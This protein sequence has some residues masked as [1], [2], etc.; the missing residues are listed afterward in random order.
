MPAMSKEVAGPV[1]Q[2]VDAIAKVAED[3]ARNAERAGDEAKKETRH[4]TRD[5]GDA[6]SDAFDAVASAAGDAAAKAGGAAR[7]LHLDDRVED[8]VKRIRSEFP[9]ERITTLVSN[10][11]REL[12][13]TDKDRYDRAYLRGWTRARTSFVGVGLLAGIAAG[14]AGAFLLDPQRG[15]QRRAALTS[16]ARDLGSTVSRQ[17]RATVAST[18]DRARG[19]AI[20]RGLVKPESDLETTIEDVAAGADPTPLVPVMDT[21]DVDAALAQQPSLD[22]VTNPDAIAQLADDGAPVSMNRGS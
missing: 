17:A 5:I 4:M 16:K 18:A 11:E 20:E 8:V 9:S 10:L 1:D 12:P 2:V 21:L 7:D 14:I 13:T 19:I 22:D 15:P 6:V 3:L